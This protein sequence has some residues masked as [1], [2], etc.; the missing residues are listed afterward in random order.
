[1]LAQMYV[2]IL[3]LLLVGAL[4][5]ALPLAALIV[6]IVALTRVRQI[7]KLSRRLDQ[8][9]LRA[10]RAPWSAPSDLQQHASIC[11][12]PTRPCRNRPASSPSRRRPRWRRTS[13][14]AGHA[15]PR[16]FGRRPPAAAARANS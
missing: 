3:A 12:R 14:G 8:L 10:A 2:E 13:R 15:V 16:R 11:H 6:A 4:V 1:M 5:L 9:E 7:E